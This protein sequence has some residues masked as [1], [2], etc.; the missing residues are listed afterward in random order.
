MQ[1]R[2][3][4]ITI[5]GQSISLGTVSES[6][7]EIWQSK[8]ASFIAP[9]SGPVMRLLVRPSQR[10][11]FLPPLESLLQVKWSLRGQL[12]NFRS[13]FEMGHSRLEEGD[14]ELWVTRKGS[15]ENFLRVYMA[16][17]GVN[18]NFLM[19]HASAVVRNGGAFVFFGPSGSG[20]STIAR[21]NKD[22]RILGDDITVI[23]R[24][25]NGYT[26]YPVPFGLLDGGSNCGYPLAGIFRLSKGSSHQITDLPGAIG[27]AQLL[28]SLPFVHQSSELSA[29][30]LTTCHDLIQFM[31]VRK[32]CFYPDSSVWS[33]LND[34][35]A[36]RSLV[37]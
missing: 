14:G 17:Q 36:A 30:V 20:K 7:T 11:H 26:V 2:I 29:A 8:F 19:V 27:C 24:D 4:D 3:L 25:G 12:L 1:L 22:G 13:N 23:R 21:L 15:V 5:A 33:F 6:L 31:P 32:L 16:S 37:S 9:P 34:Y 18:N 28:A 10:D 35:A